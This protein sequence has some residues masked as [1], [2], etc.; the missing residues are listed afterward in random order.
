MALANLTNN[1]QRDYRVDHELSTTV[2]VQKWIRVS[3]GKLGNPRL[4]QILAEHIL[5]ITRWIVTKQS[6]KV[7]LRLVTFQFFFLSSIVYDKLNFVEKNAL[8]FCRPKSFSEVR[9]S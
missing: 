6:N 9:I 4:E 3:F 8:P 7:P 5:G 1:T 2:L